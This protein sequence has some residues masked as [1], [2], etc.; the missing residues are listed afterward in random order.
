MVKKIAQIQFVEE[1]LKR[2]AY[3][4]LRLCYFDYVVVAENF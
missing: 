1:D 3:L 2:G 4:S